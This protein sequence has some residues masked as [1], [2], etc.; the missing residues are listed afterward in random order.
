MRCCDLNKYFV[1]KDEQSVVYQ[2]I[3]MRKRLNWNTKLPVYGNGSQTAMKSYKDRI[4]SEFSR[5]LDD[6]G[7]FIYCMCTSDIRGNI[8]YNPYELKIVTKS[9]IMNSN[10]YHIVTATS[11]TRVKFRFLNIRHKF[12]ILTFLGTFSEF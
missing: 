8:L 1:S 4:D 9:E 7:R 5:T 3:Q 10:V 11:V 2:I 6:D 12:S